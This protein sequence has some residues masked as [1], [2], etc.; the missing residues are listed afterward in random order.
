M[1][2][3]ST[4]FVEEV[5]SISALRSEDWSGVRTR[6]LFQT[7]YQLRIINEMDSETIKHD[8]DSFVSEYESVCSVRNCLTL[9]CSI[10]SHRHPS[11][12]RRLTFH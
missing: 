12:S 4:C 11:I 8:M 9:Q 10:F 3:S 7:F 1:H 2:A 5:R 6:S